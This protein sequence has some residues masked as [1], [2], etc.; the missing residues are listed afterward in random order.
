MLLGSAVM[1]DGTSSGITAL[2]GVSQQRVIRRA[3]D[4]AGIAA[5]SVDYVE[6]H[7]TGTPLGDPIEVN[8]L[9][10]AYGPREEVG[11]LRLGTAKS[12]IGHLEAA[13]GIAG[14]CKVLASLRHG[15]LPA[16]RHS[17]PR[18]PHLHWDDLGVEVVDQLA[19]WP[20]DAHRPRR[21]GISAFGLSGTNVHLLVEQ[22]PVDVPTAP[23]AP[24]ERTVDLMEGDR[25]D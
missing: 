9:A 4:V 11:P 20:V 13:A 10:A 3:L 19:P 16:T 15:A 17:S 1:H 24:N 2:N 7:G 25:D 23:T 22:A 8:A 5:D 14:L 6:C 12:V 21:A 18:N